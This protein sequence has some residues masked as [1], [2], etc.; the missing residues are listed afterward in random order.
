MVC[1]GSVGG[2]FLGSPLGVSIGGLHQG[3]PLESA[4]GVHQRSIGV[5]LSIG[6]TGL[7]FF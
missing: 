4:S 3:S 6:V 2:L 7:T 1:Q 5:P